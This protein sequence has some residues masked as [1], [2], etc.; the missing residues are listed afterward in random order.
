MDVKYLKCMTVRV[1]IYPL[2][3]RTVRPASLAGK[4]KAGNPVQLMAL[5]E[6]LSQA[7]VSLPISGTL[8][9]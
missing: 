1:I 3:V 4:F 6:S 5:H 2:R 7:S 9:V 8:L